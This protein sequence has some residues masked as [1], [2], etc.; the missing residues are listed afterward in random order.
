MQ[1]PASASDLVPRE[2]HRVHLRLLHY[3]PQVV[4]DQRGLRGQRGVRAEERWQ[5]RQ[6]ATRT[7]AVGPSRASV[8]SAGPG[9]AADLIDAGSG[10]TTSGGSS[11]EPLPESLTN[12]LW[13]CGAMQSGLVPFGSASRQNYRSVQTQ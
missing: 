8:C 1:R 4:A 12:F 11:P 7:T 5:R 9:A 10:T 13:A 6:P 2:G 3:Q